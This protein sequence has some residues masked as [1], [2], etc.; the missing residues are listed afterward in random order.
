MRGDADGPARGHWSNDLSAE[1]GRGRH[2]A[3]SVRTSEKDAELVR[4][5]DEFAL[6]DSTVLAR[7]PV[8]SR[9]QERGAYTDR[10][11]LTKEI[12]VRRCRRAHHGEVVLTGLEFGHRCDRVH[13]E[14]RLATE[15]GRRNAAGVAGC[16]DVVQGDEAELSRMSR[17]ARHDNTFGVEERVEAGPSTASPCQRGCASSVSFRDLDQ[18]VN[19]DRVTLGGN[20]Q[21]VDVDARHLGVFERETTEADEDVGEHPAIDRLLPSEG[22]QQGLRLE[23]IDLTVRVVEI[24]R[25][26]TEHDV[27]DRFGEHSSETEH[28]HRP[29]GRITHHTRNELAISTDHRRH[30]QSDG[31]I[32]G[33]SG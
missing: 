22:A 13:A 21:R 18:R 25:S 8:T 26:W 20:D 27:A 10:R 3:L 15:I 31:P 19:G 14:H 32:L 24:E 2:H 4:D 1:G 6:R 7:L 12:D 28:H 33:P 11:A 30:Q 16:E 29:E 17:R 5:G 23:G 9:S